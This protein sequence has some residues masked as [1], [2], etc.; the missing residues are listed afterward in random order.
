MPLIALLLLLLSSLAC[1]ATDATPEF[2]AVP[3]TST[4]LDNS[5]LVPTSTIQTTTQDKGAIAGW[6]SRVLNG[7]DGLW[8]EVI[9]FKLDDTYTTGICLLQTQLSWCQGK[10]VAQ[11]QGRYAINENIIHFSNG[12]MLQENLDYLGQP[13]A[14]TVNLSEGFPEDYQWLLTDENILLTNDN[15]LNRQ[16]NKYTAT[17]PG[18]QNQ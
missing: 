8:R 13:N 6:W 12:L 11:I 10:A 3:M 9:E 16:F 17:P 14:P 4:N 1:G 18:W 7:T 15:N 2:T 5:I